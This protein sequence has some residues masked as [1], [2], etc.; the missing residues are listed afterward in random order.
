M[1][2]NIIEENKIKFIELLKSINRE[3]AQI[4]KLIDWLNNT[5]FFTAPASTKYHCDEKGGLC[6]HSLNVYYC[7]I[8]MK[9]TFSDYINIDSDSFL[10]TALLH[11]ISKANYYEKYYRNVKNEQT[12][13]WE[14][15]S[16]YRI[17]ED[18]FIYGNHEE[19]SEYIIRKFIPLTVDESSAII[20]HHGGKGYDSTQTDLSIIFNKYPLVTLLHLADL[21]ATFILEQK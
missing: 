17:R 9:D 8:A 10:I 18:R 6:Q 13:Q 7:I 1:E 11:D 15:K 20:H 21:E 4:D 2:N 14:K 5:D 16:E 19:T 12:D 3:N